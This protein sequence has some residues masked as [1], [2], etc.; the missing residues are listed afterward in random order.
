MTSGKVTGSILAEFLVFLC[1][2]ARE[3][4]AGRERRNEGE[5]PKVGLG[6]E[7][8][9]QTVRPFA[10]CIRPYN[11][12]MRF[13]KFLVT[14]GAISRIYASM[15]L[16]PLSRTYIYVSHDEFICP[17]RLPLTSSTI[18]AIYKWTDIVL[19]REKA[20]Y[21]PACTVSLSARLLVST[22]IHTYVCCP[23]CFYRS[24]FLL[25]CT[26]ENHRYHVRVALSLESDTKP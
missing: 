15:Y 9:S 12:P 16:A 7:H 13:C 19:L 25:T 3:E 14:R 4:K 2:Q 21:M 1:R 11:L 23:L 20:E 8:F 24:T 17:R 5:V 10:R 6:T 18:A 22:Y 26:S